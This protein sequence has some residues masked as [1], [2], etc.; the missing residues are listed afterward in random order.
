VSSV[1]PPTPHAVAGYFAKRRRGSLTE[2]SD[3]EI[4]H[5]E[6][7]WVVEICGLPESEL[8]TS[9]TGL[10]AAQAS[11]QPAPQAS[12]NDAEDAN[13]T[14]TPGDMLTA[15]QP[16][17]P[18]ISAPA[19]PRR[20]HRATHRPNAVCGRCDGAFRQTRGPSSRFCADCREPARKEAAR[21]HMRLVRGVEGA[22][23][24]DVAR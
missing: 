1:L 4:W 7:L 22:D 23:S 3:A 21:L 5:N 6:R 10:D 19:K 20:S 2:F 12:F 9:L 11:P 8:D 13:G 15:L 14:N 17:S 16:P 24:N 18:S